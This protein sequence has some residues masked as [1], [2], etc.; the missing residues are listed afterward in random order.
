MDLHIDGVSKR[1]K[2][3]VWGL[4]VD[5]GPCLADLGLVWYH[6]T[7]HLQLSFESRIVGR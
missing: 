1:Y 4:R 5:P 7:V 2:G 3:G 6:R